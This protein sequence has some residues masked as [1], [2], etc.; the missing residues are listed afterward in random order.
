MGGY[1]RRGQFVTARKFRQLGRCNSLLSKTARP[2][3]VEYLHLLFIFMFY[4]QRVFDQCC[5]I[6]KADL[7]PNFASAAS[8]GG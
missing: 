1:V 7:V 3:I 2:I 5:E 8:P 6:Y 4:P